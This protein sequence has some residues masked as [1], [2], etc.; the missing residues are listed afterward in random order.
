[1]SADPFK[2]E[3]VAKSMIPLNL[4]RWQHD[5]VAQAETLLVVHVAARVPP[6][7]VSKEVILEIAVILYTQ[8]CTRCL[9]FAYIYIC[10]SPYLSANH[11]FFSR[12][13]QLGT[14]DREF[15]RNMHMYNVQ[16]CLSVVL[17]AAMCPFSQ[18]QESF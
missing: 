18:P 13:C 2:F 14:N 9:V 10:I 1:M 7:A 3:L 6:N 15:K 11:Q 16:C 4:Y 12:S 8:D 17:N 5:I